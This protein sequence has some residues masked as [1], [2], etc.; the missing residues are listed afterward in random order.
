M[1]TTLKKDLK[2]RYVRL[3]ISLLVACVAL[4]STLSLTFQPD[5]WAVIFPLLTMLFPIKT[6][7]DPYFITDDNKLGGNG[8]IDILLILSLNR[9]KS[10]GFQVIYTWMKGGKERTRCFYPADESLFIETLQQINPNI[11][12]N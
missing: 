6:I 5:N 10:G 4:L 9:L 8:Q 1:K 12:L 7:L 2:S 11:K 3:G